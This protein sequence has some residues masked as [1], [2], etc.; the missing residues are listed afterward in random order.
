MTLYQIK[1]DTSRLSLRALARVPTPRWHILTVNAS[2]KKPPAN[3]RSYITSWLTF[4]TTLTSTTSTCPS[5]TQ[6]NHAHIS[7]STFTHPIFRTPIPT[8]SHRQHLPATKCSSK[9]TAH[10][11]CS[12][13]HTNSQK[14]RLQ[15]ATPSHPH[16]RYDPVPP[17][18][19]YSSTR[20]SPS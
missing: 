3:L 7:P 2:N 13:T 18:A 9:P 5:L 16:P 10:K 17:P 11:V 12:V 15:A 14:R 4:H 19:V 6:S 20:L 1:H 8:G